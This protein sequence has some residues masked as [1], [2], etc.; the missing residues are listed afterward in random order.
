MCF[1]PTDHSCHHTANVVSDL[2]HMSHT[3]RIQ[4]LVLHIYIYMRADEDGDK[5][6]HI[7]VR[8]PHMHLQHDAN[9]RHFLL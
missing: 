3:V 6:K 9:Y 2:E 5:A 7:N 8:C 4:Q 1:R